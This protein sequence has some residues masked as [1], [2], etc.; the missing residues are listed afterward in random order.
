MEVAVVEN[1]ILGRQRTEQ[2]EECVGEI[3]GHVLSVVEHDDVV[4]RQRR[5]ESP[6][7]VMPVDV[8]ATQQCVKGC[9]GRQ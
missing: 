6:V 3:G 7:V 4:T 9:L 8:I 1:G 2:I 5:V